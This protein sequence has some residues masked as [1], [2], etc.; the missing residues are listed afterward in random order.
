MSDLATKAVQDARAE[1]KDV[2]TAMY[3]TA[4]G[5]T[6]AWDSNV[7]NAQLK[8]QKKQLERKQQKSYDKYAAQR[9]ADA[10]WAVKNYERLTG[11][12]WNAVENI[13][14]SD[15]TIDAIKRKQKLW[16]MTEGIDGKVGT[17]TLKAKNKY[18][19]Q[20]KQ[21]EQLAIQEAQAEAETPGL[22]DKIQN[23]YDTTVSNISAERKSKQEAEQK[24]Y[25][26]ALNDPK[27]HAYLVEQAQ[28]HK[29]Q[30]TAVILQRM[31]KGAI[32]NIKSAVVGPKIANATTF[33]SNFT[34]MPAVK[35]N[36][37][38]IALQTRDA[39]S[40]NVDQQ[41]HSNGEASYN[42]GINYRN[43]YGVGVSKDNDKLAHPSQYIYGAF[44]VTED[45]NGIKLKDKYDF[46][47]VDKPTWD[48]TK[49]PSQIGYDYLRWAFGE[50]QRPDTYYE[51]NLIFSKDYIADLYKKYLESQQVSEKRLGGKLNYFNFLNN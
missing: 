41:L 7:T 12:K 34:I 47:K 46:S 9:K 20:H 51:N 6:N 22:I 23:L 39:Q 18:D 17:N 28:Q 29:V 27:F 1:K 36:A 35:Q 8:T 31:A 38:G 3:N 32:Q 21:I 37:L 10:E 24:L 33:N 11:K 16:G 48:S 15:Y 5:S 25:E 43:T 50:L 49:S 2:A 30:N 45:A 19:A 14:L 40:R 13:D 4:L 44:N 42:T 26:Q